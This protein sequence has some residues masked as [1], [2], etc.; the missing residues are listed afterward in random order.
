MTDQREGN[1][2]NAFGVGL[3][4]VIAGALGSLI[5]LSFLSKDTR[6]KIEKRMDEFKE[7]AAKTLDDIK[8]K[9][10]DIENGIRENAEVL[11]EGSKDK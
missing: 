6:R 5:A 7:N 1:N 11:K 2:L 9:S 3:I 10:E 4:G 8:N